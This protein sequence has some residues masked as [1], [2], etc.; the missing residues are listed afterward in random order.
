MTDCC[1]SWSSLA[2]C[3]RLNDVGSSL[4]AAF[5]LLVGTSREIIVSFVGFLLWRLGG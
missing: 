1:A 3:K 4:L 2:I 5:V